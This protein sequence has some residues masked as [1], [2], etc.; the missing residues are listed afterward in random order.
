MVEA[1]EGAT[2]VKLSSVL[3]ANTAMAIGFVGFVA[4]LELL[5]AWV[6]VHYEVVD[7]IQATVDQYP[8]PPLLW[9]AAALTMTGSAALFALGLLSWTRRSMRRDRP[10]FPLR[11]SGRVLLFVYLAVTV[12]AIPLG[13][14]AGVVSPRSDQRWGGLFAAIVLTA[15]VTGI[16]IVDRAE[17]HDR[18]GGDHPDRHSLG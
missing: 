17:R 10:L 18:P 7:R 5:G 2:V 3:V 13:V 11:P 4:G 6:M 16:V 12:P 1:D 15:L 8:V 9:Q 14:L